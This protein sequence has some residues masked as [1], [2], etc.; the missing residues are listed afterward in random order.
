MGANVS[1]ENRITFGNNDAI[2]ATVEHQIFLTKNKQGKYE[3]NDVCFNDIRDIKF[4][5]MDI[6]EGY[7]GY[8]KF[9]TQM[10]E[11]GI[12]VGKLADEAAEK[13]ITTQLKNQILNMFNKK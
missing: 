8:K 12:D 3:I 11:M 10:L 9:K 7:N 1:F 2:T 6:D 13:L 5:G 4:L